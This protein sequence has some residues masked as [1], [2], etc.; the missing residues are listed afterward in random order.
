ETRSQAGRSRTE[1]VT[2]LGRKRGQAPLHFELH[3]GDGEYPEPYESRADYWQH[4][5]AAVRARESTLRRRRLCRIFRSR[6]QSPPGT[7]DEV[8]IL[9]KRANTPSRRNARL[10][11]CRSLLLMLI[12]VRSVQA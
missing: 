3:H 7:A 8:H 4:H 9:R 11:L 1:R 10:W 5:I 6:Q 12:C 2:L